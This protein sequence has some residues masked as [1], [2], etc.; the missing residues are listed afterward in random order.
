MPPRGAAT[1][2]AVGARAVGEILAR[3]ESMKPPSVPAAFGAFGCLGEVSQLFSF[4]F[5]LHQGPLVFLGQ[6]NPMRV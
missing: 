2:R 3:S 5:L 1:R 4:G 6:V